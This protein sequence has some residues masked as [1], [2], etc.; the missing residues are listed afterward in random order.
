M[1]A[2]TASDTMRGRIWL[3]TAL[4]LLTV[5]SLLAQVS[6][7]LEGLVTDP[8]RAVVPG[9][10][11]AARNNATNITYET[12]SN[13]VGRYV[14]VTLPPGT[15][16]LTA[17]LA[18]FKQIV[19][20]GIQIQVGAA[21]K[22]DF[23][24]EPGEIVETVRVTA[25]TP[26]LDQTTARLGSVIETRDAEELPLL[27]RNAMMLYYLAPGMDVIQ[28]LGSQQ[29]T[30]GVDGLAP[31][32]GNLK[33]EGVF[34]GWTSY[35]YSAAEPS[36]A[37]PQEAVGEYRITTSG[38]GADSG[39]GSGAHVSVAL[40]SGQNDFHGSLFEFNR[41]TA[42]NANNF[43]NNRSGIERPDYKRNQFG[44]SLGGP[45][46]RDRTFFFGTMEWDRL[47]TF[48]TYNAV[49]Y[50]QTLRD[51]IFRYRTNGANTTSCVDSSGNPLCPYG[52]IDLLTV[53]K[54][55][56]GKDTYF[57]PRLLAAMPLP[58]NFDSGDGFNTAGYRYVV[59]GNRPTT[60][61]L[62]K[63]NHRFSDRQDMSISVN[64]LGHSYDAYHLASGN[65]GEH[66]ERPRRGLQFR[67]MSTF[68]NAL[69]NELSIGA[70]RGSFETEILTG[71][72]S[73]T[74][75]IYASGASGNFVYVDGRNH[76]RLPNSN[77]GF[78]DNMTW[79]KKNHTIRFGAEMWW[80][81]FNSSTGNNAWP[82]ITTANANNPANV[83][84]RT[85]LHA[86]DR[87]RAQQ[88]TNDLTGSIGTITQTYNFAT[89]DGYIPFASQYSPAR[90]REWAVYFQDDWRIRPNFALE[91]G[92]RYDLVPMGWIANGVY[93]QPLGGVAGS[94]GQF[95]PAGKATEWGLTP[96]GHAPVDTDWNNFGPRLGFS[97][98][99]AGTGRT[100]ISGAYGISYD[101]AMLKTHALFSQA[102][103][104]G[105]VPVTVN[106]PTRLSDSLYETMLPLPVPEVFAPLGFTRENVRNYSIERDLSTPYVQSWSLRIAR[107]LKDMKIEVSYVGNHAVGQ[108]QAANLNQVEMRS[109][110][111]LD[112]FKIAQRNLEANGSPVKG[113]SL[114][115]LQQLF[116][117]IP[118]A[119][120]PTIAR[121]EAA[122]LASYL[123]ITAIRTNRRG[124]LIPLS[125]LPENFFRLNPQIM[126]LCITGNNSHSTWNGMKVVV[127]RPFSKGL[128]FTMNYTLGKGFTNYIPGQNLFGDFRDERNHQLDK[129]YTPTDATHRVIANWIWELP[130]G[131][132]KPFLNRPSPVVHALVTGWQFNGIFNWA[133]GYPLKLTTGRYMLSQN[134]ASTPNFTGEL[135]NMSEPVDSGTN[136]T[137]LTSNQ[138]AQFSDPGPGEPGEL[139]L[140]SSIRGPGYSS[141][142]MSLFKHF[143]TERWGK[144]LTFQFR[145]E[146]YNAFNQVNWGSP[147][148]NINSG[149]FGN[150]INARDARVG[151]VALKVMF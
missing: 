69:I 55:R 43:F 147:N 28:S 56:L 144:N 58:N 129:T 78:S 22:I 29:Q 18:G 111:F 24:L 123:D 134:V 139:P 40:K 12:V 14:F 151:Q 92:L 133:T 82:K 127:T 33:V 99:P 137:T 140:Y 131:R 44:F 60:Q 72:E 20:E 130:F 46:I 116:A 135:F 109:N 74:G 54:T 98:D 41:N 84:A 45:I 145:L 119:Q 19:R 120:Y 49:V 85:G 113:E 149:S 115:A 121:G 142:D 68:S 5:P 10:T 66:T 76:Q 26:L 70:S 79:I 4:L 21:V 88:L 7:R 32:T 100:S 13:E 86:N 17:T 64:Q 96:D 63:I 42:Y 1:Q 48:N 81:A 95:G 102:N 75:A 73:P 31:H 16:T 94:M 124:G 71:Q 65:P 122:A 30:G 37:V 93:I 138:R 25:S 105:Q 62:I 126:N 23:A 148:L 117:Y 11:I 146:L 83:P 118:A 108:W 2:L 6:A 77:M 143:R 39:R 107:E 141:F 59:S 150:V 101:K 61:S 110:G 97:W 103:Y 57:L 90:N 47:K 136:I 114:G 8:S 52:T 36:V 132:H 128:K 87:S 91:M 51:G 3:L 106:N 34:A 27:D 38:V 104:G 125:G 15:Y 112:A 9:A 67:L 53:D 80:G 35:D 89:V 50:T